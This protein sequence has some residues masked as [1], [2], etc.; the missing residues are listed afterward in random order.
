MSCP[1]TKPSRLT[2]RRALGAVAA[3]CAL[4]L[5]GP[6]TAAGPHF[7]T[8]LVIA[9]FSIRLTPSHP[10]GYLPS[11]GTP[12]LRWHNPPPPPLPP[13]EPPFVLYNPPAAPKPDPS[14]ADTATAAAPKSEAPPL[15][16]KDFLPFFEHENS[17]P[18]GKAGPREG[19]QFAP[20]RPALPTSS[21]EYRQQ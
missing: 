4:A 16:P 5:A 19:L 18:P 1:A 6:E 8:T 17:H 13:T 20:A 14:R 9:P 3:A 10:T 15:R 21:A 2:A 7:P 12:P 11:S